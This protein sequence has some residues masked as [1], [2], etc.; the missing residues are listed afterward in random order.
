MEADVAY[1]ETAYR[2]TE[3]W[4]AA[5][6]YEFADFNSEVDFSTDSVLEHEEIALGLNYWFNPNL[7][8]KLSYHLV[9]GNRFASPG[10]FGDYVMAAQQGFDE[11]THLILI[12]T[13]FSF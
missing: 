10:N 2:F 9:N 4:Q 7:V 5:A 1:I 11:E 12:G 13:Q 8:F 6:R 3:H